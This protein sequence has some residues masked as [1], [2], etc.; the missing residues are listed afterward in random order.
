MIKVIK[1]GNVITMDSER[2]KVE[3]LDIVIEDDKI[4]EIVKDYS[5][6]YD[7]L[8]DASDRVVMPGLV[9]SHAH[10]GMSLF[11]A[12]NDNL[13]LNS[14]L[15]NYIW[16]IEDKLTDDDVYYATL[17]T[18]IEMIKS[19]T[20][21]CNEMYQNISHDFFHLLFRN[22]IWNKT[23]CST[24]CSQFSEIPIRSAFLAVLS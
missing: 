14:W 12:T 5:G 19:G 6:E 18:C 24:L 1:N 11:R 8:I 9:N 23:L 20:T 16:P 7:Y 17:Y 22:I 15:E 3:K 21:S 4:K 10:L 13:T 2:E